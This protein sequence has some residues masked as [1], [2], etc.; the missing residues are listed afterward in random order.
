MLS[1]T[2]LVCIVS[3]YLTPQ[4]GRDGVHGADNWRTVPLGQVSFSSTIQCIKTIYGVKLDIRGW[5]ANL[6][7]WASVIF[8]TV[9]I[10]AMVCFAFRAKDPCMG[11]SQRLRGGRR[12]LNIRGRLNK[13]AFDLHRTLLD[14][15]IWEPPALLRNR[16]Y[17]RLVV[18]DKTSL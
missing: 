3:L 17:T 13:E 15:D 4:F 11:L 2:L 9:L 18:A 16:K 12:T 7:N 8:V 1:K 5:Y 10:F 14:R 6:F